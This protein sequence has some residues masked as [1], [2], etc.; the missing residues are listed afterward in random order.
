MPRAQVPQHLESVDV[1]EA[2]VEDDEIEAVFAEQSIG[3]L[4]AHGVLDLVPGPA[5]Q[6]DEAFGK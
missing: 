6:L 2:Y 5:Q 4:A 3:M 1:G